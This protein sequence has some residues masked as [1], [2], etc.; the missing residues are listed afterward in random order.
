MV[1]AASVAKE[2]LLPYT[3]HFPGRVGY[4][5]AAKYNPEHRLA[6]ISRHSLNKLEAVFV[7]SHASSICCEHVMGCCAAYV[8]VH[9]QIHVHSQHGNVTA[10]AKH[11]DSAA[12]LLA[13]CLAWLVACDM[14]MF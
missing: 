7:I 12:A 6:A 11:V 1:D 4:N 8:L 5:Y 13:K 14:K 3:L 9:A 2:D 10:S